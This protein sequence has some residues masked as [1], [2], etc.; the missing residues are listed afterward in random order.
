LRHFEI[1]FNY[2]NGFTVYHK[3]FPITI[4]SQGVISLDI[5]DRLE[6]RNEFPILFIG[7]G[8]SMRYLDSFPNWTS[9]LEEFWD[10]CKF[11][12]SY[13]GMYNNK[14]AEYK[15]KF[16]LLS[17]KE[18]D[19]EINSELG[20]LIHKK[21]NEMFNNDEIKLDGFT[22]KDAHNTNISSFKVAIA[23]KFNSYSIKQEKNDEAKKFID[24]IGKASIVIT[25]NYD[26]FIESEFKKYNESGLDVYIGQNGFFE[27][28]EG[29][30]ELFKIHGSA[31]NP[32]SIIIDKDD[33]NEFERDS[34]LITAKILSQMIHSPII[35]LGYSLTDVNVRNFIKDFSRSIKDSD[36][37]DLADRLIIV[38][39]TEGEND[40]IEQV[41]DDRDLNCRFTYIKTDNYEKI[42]GKIL[43]INQGV[44]PLEVRKYKKTIRTLIEEAGKQEA[45]KSVL[46]SSTTLD[47]IQHMINN[48]DFKNIAIAIGDSRVIFQIPDNVT[49]MYSYLTDDETLVTNVALRFLYGQNINT[50]VPFKKF[51]TNEILETAQ[52]NNSMKDKLNSRRVKYESTEKIIG[53]IVQSNQIERDDFQGIIDEFYEEYKRKCYD[54]ICFNFD[55]FEIS[56]IKNFIIEELEKLLEE[57]KTTVE[58]SLRKLILVFDLKTNSH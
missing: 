23:N 33:Y 15:N 53:S 58:T 11:E 43:K 17:D 28:T 2:R 6:K 8:M 18:V 40:L 20:T 27:P 56:E 16:P 47:E 10:Q 39:R 12:K 48:G 34:V 7:S 35:F 26:R 5:L 44:S 4:N 14:R 37:I 36:S 30:A 49:Y 57:Q 1:G 55:N 19:F 46:V 22:P 24:I 50:N 32:N 52:I 29:S 21:F 51:L 3:D 38:E 9:L 54:I 45:L 42:Y 25:T 13:Y 31:E 41:I